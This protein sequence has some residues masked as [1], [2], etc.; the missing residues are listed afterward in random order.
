MAKQSKVPRDNVDESME[1]RRNWATGFSSYGG[2][3]I[4]SKHS[5]G[6][7]SPIAKKKKKKRK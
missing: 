6:R 1:M 5:K 7:T 4:V 3:R 2:R